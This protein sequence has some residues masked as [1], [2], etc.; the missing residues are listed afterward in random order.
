M[1]SSGLV[2]LWK[3]RIRADMQ[4][5]FE[6]NY[7]PNGVWAKLFR[8]GE[9]FVRTELIR[10][11]SQPRRYV[12]IDQWISAEKYES[13]RRKYCLEYDA[14]DLEC[15]AFTESEIEIGRFEKINSEKRSGGGLSVRRPR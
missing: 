13:F 15:A 3:F 12:T 14:L 4:E 7:G 9:G 11:W 10:D 6:Q 5:A 1:V 8:K 2:L